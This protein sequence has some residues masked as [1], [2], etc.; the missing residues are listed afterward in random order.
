MIHDWTIDGAQN[1]IRNI[2]RTWNLQKMASGVN[3]DLLRGFD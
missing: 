2:A 1:T 3:D